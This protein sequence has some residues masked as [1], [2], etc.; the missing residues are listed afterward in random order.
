MLAD[1]DGA[2]LDL[3]RRFG[4]RFDE[5]AEQAVGRRAQA[6]RAE[7]LSSHA[8]YIRNP[9]S[10]NVER[11]LRTVGTRGDFPLALEKPRLRVLAKRPL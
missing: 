7:P 8:S 4:A 2:N 5:S 11:P 6:Y 3:P 10:D 1:E 9:Q